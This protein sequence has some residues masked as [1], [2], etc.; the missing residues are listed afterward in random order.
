MY[1]PFPLPHLPR[2]TSKQPRY[3]WSCLYTWL[4]KI[5]FRYIVHSL[6]CFLV[7]QLRSRVLSSLENFQ[8]K[9]IILF[10]ILQINSKTSQLASMYVCI[11]ICMYICMYVYFC[12]HVS[13]YVWIVSCICMCMFCYC[14][15]TGLWMSLLFYMYKPVTY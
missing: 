5:V 15:K 2:F 1:L 14:Y 6:I 12:V 10:P 11:N 7:P 9:F 3:N 4:T 13:I 8:W